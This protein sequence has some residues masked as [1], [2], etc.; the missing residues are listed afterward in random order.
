[1]AGKS[2]SEEF[3]RQAVDLYETAPGA[4]VR[5]I[6]QD[7][8]IVRGALR[9]WPARYG[10]GRRTGADGRGGSSRVWWRV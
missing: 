6:A 4:T 10:T 5:G 3:R 7:P 8:G 1:M 2:C 9:Q